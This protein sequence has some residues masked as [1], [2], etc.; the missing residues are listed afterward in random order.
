M[1]REVEVVM[2]AFEDVVQTAEACKDAAESLHVDLEMLC[3]RNR[4]LYDRNAELK[5]DNERLESANAQVEAENEKLRKR[6]GIPTVM[7]GGGDL[8]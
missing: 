4:E 6:L 1:S 7:D 3:R 8:T 2:G 5:A